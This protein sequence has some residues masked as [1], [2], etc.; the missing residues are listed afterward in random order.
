MRIYRNPPPGWKNWP[1]VEPVTP[2]ESGVTVHLA[3]ISPERE[4]WEDI[5]AGVYFVY[6][7]AEHDRKATRESL[8]VVDIA[9]GPDG[10]VET[11]LYDGEDGVAVVHKQY[12]EDGD[13][14]MDFTV[15]DD[16][17]ETK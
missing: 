11:L 7:P 5:G 14:S 13:V 9:I 4:V 15:L 2:Q 1:E 16:R 10:P 17:E 3:R 8:T 6:S 12:R